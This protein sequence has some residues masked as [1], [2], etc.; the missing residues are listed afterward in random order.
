MIRRLATPLT[1]L[2]DERMLPLS[3]H[4]VVEMLHDSALTMTLTLHCTGHFVF[5]CV[6]V[7]WD[8]AICECV[9]IDVTTMLCKRFCYQDLT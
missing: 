9:Q 7:E 4:V 1:V 3:T 6:I 5:H 8:L 2:E